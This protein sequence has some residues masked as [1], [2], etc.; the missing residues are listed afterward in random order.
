MRNISI[1]RL[2]GCFT[3][4]AVVAMFC[5]RSAA[6]T[7]PTA[8]PAVAMTRDG[9]PRCGTAGGLLAVA[10][11]DLKTGDKTAWTNAWL[12]IS[13]GKPTT[14]PVAD[15]APLPIGLEGALGPV[16]TMGAER[17]VYSVAVAGN[18]Q[19]ITLCIRLR[20]GVTADAAVKW[21]HRN[22]RTAPHFDHD[23]P[24]LVVSVSAGNGNVVS[25]AAA[26]PLSPRADDVRQ[27]LNCWGDDVP[28]KVVY[29][30][31]ETVKKRLMQEGAPPPVLMPLANLYF[32]CKYIYFGAKLGAHPQIESR[33]V[34]PDEN[35]A[36]QVITELQ[37]MR[38]ALKQPDNDLNLPPALAAI[39][40][41]FQPTRD[42]NVA[43]LSM[44]QKDLSNLFAAVLVASMNGGNVPQSQVRQQP[45]S[46]DWKPIDP[47]TDSAAAQMRLI[48]AAIA[49]YDQD[50]QALPAS[51]DDLVSAK[52][53]PGAETLRDPRS[54]NK[55]GF[56]YVKPDANKLA[57]IPSRDKTAILFED[58]DGQ[59]D[60]KGLTGYADGR[61]ANAP[62]TGN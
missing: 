21:L 60:A 13:G 36:D 54:G 18:G 47:A 52:L 55:N 48:L 11:F 23:G 10:V 2:A 6:Q 27:D 25:G 49:E 14:R 59:P 62:S 4:A 45:V 7:E 26:R 41:Q 1:G 37:T 12:V 56:I 31:S 19:N 33:W 30:S 44:S 46:P 39:L 8:S 15:N 34:A 35:G 61:V 9:P 24:W 20:P 40:D 58:R 38:T 22:I 32:S 50:H 28:V 5:G 53:L 3:I 17:L 43:R 57:D 16:F 51:L 29:V 42:G